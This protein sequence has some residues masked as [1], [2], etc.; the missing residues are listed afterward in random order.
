ML[1]I[2]ALG[3]AASAHCVVCIRWTDEVRIAI[4]VGGCGVPNL[5]EIDDDGMGMNN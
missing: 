1:R 5:H 2:F 4:G 3:L